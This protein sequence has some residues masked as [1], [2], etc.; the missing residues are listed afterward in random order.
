MLTGQSQNGAAAVAEAFLSLKAG[1]HKL[2][3]EKEPCRSSIDRNSSFVDVFFRKT[4][5]HIIL[6]HEL[7]G[8][9]KEL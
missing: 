3:G 6:A 5:K 7:L 2:L 1:I 4:S 9:I 8:K